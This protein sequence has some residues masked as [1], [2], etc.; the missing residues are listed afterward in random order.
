MI[1]KKNRYNIRKLYLLNPTYLH[2]LSIHCTA[3]CTYSC[4]CRAHRKYITT[5]L[6]AKVAAMDPVT[7]YS[8]S[9]R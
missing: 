7:E 3:Q 2:Y 4:V 8:R 6:F 5:I 1:R 9:L